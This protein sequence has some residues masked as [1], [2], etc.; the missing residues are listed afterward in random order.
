MDIKFPPPAPAAT[1]DAPR[2]KMDSGSHKAAV[3]ASAAS[4]FPSTNSA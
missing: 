2:K 1:V 4:Y 3:A